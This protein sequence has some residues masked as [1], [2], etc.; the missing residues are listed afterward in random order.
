M[1]TNRKKKHFHWNELEKP[2]L[3]FATHW[4]KIMLAVYKAAALN[5]TAPTCILNSKPA[6]AIKCCC[7]HCKEM[8]P[9][10]TLK[11]SETESTLSR[12]GHPKHINKHIAMSGTSVH[13]NF[14]FVF[15]ME[16]Q[17]Y[18]IIASSFPSL[19][20]HCFFSHRVS[21]S[22]TMLQTKDSK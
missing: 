15:R 8:Y 2:S 22:Q 18:S 16:Q 3:H 12:Q 20:F 5:L 10:T 6:F 7:I 21:K 17:L 14:L 9:S 13:Q 1:K 19:S 11:S 4:S